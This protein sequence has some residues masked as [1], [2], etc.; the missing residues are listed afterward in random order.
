MPLT[1]PLC[2]ISKRFKTTEGKHRL[3]HPRRST[4][5]SRATNA[6]PV[7]VSPSRCVMS[8]ETSPGLMVSSNVIRYS[9]PPSDPMPTLRFR[10]CGGRGGGAGSAVSICSSCRGSWV[11]QSDDVIG[12]FHLLL[13]RWVARG[14]VVVCIF[15]ENILYVRRLDRT[16]KHRPWATT[17]PHS[18]VPFFEF[19]M[20]R[21]LS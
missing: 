4:L 5:T 8:N 17:T 15:A 21:H 9:A 19:F 20:H 6:A 16:T 11:R 3:V 14:V 18:N 12:K 10:V 1:S 7:P 2:E 13:L